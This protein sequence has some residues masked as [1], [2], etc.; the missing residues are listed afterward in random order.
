LVLVGLVMLLVIAA[1]PSHAR[2]RSGP[3]S[4][5]ATAAPSPTTTIPTPA[6]TTPHTT[7]RT[8]GADTTT[9]VSA[10]T[11]T[12]DAGSLPQTAAVPVATSPE[13]EVEMASLWQGVTTGSLSPALPAFFPQAAYRQLKAVY[14]PVG[15]YGGRLVQ[16][17][18]LD[19]Q[20][21]HA[22]LGTEAAEAQLIGVMVPSNYVHWVPPQ[23]CENRVGYFEVANSRIVFRA[24]DQIRS[25]GIASLISWR[26]VWYVVHLGAVVRAAAEGTVDDP[27]AGAGTSWYSPTC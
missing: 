18:A 21:A 24:G 4:S 3:I 22:L 19:L 14:D 10:V 27:E 23:A 9:T 20:A 2:D 11:T 7:L 6:T 16:D 15:D 8:A 26:G 12:T 17:Y 13:F 1:L 5:H 25:F